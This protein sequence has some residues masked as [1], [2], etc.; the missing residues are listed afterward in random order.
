MTGAL[1][2]AMLAG[3]SMV[4]VSLVLAALWATGGA[5]S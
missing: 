1:V 3:G 5:R 4:F 2:Q